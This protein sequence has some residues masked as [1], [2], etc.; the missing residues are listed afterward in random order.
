MQLD[1]FSPN[2]TAPV[3]LRYKVIAYVGAWILALLATNPD[4]GLRALAWM[5]PLGLFAF[6]HLRGAQAGGWGVFLVCIGVYLVHAYFYFR[7]RSTRSTVLLFAFL[8]ILLIC[9][10]SG[11]RNMIHVR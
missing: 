6:V 8:V 9:N 2:A 11:C 10:V 1:E 4:G 7:S 5:F 3:R